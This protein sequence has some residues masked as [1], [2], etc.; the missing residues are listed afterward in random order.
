LLSTCK[1][2]KLFSNSKK[3]LTHSTKIYP[4]IPRLLVCHTLWQTLKVCQSFS[5][6]PIQNSKFKI[7]RSFTE[8]K[9]ASWRSWVCDEG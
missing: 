6:P 5:T 7:H 9:S 8:G 3:K 4:P 1:N 2:I